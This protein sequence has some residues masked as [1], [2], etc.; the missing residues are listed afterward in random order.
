MTRGVLIFLSIFCILWI[1]SV[2]AETIELKNGEDIVG[3]IVQETEEALV[4]SKPEGSFIFSIS[5]D[6]IKNVRPSTPAE[7]Q[8]ERLRKK[9]K[10]KVDTEEEKARREK[11]KKDRLE[12]YEQE[13]LAAKRARGR[14][15]I[16][17][18]ED[19]F[20]VVEALL[21]NKIK[22]ALLVDSGASRVVI[23]EAIAKQ[24][25]I[26]DLDE[27]PKIHATLADGSITTGIAITL[28]SVKVGD[29]EVKDVDTTVSKTPPGG[30]LDGLLGMT[31]LQY[32]HV[33]LDSKENCL[34][35]EKY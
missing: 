30:G 19:R 22:A 26:E 15:K 32:F 31:F 28:D 2:L 27:K 12:K 1:S 7:L 5:R 10:G 24:L 14:I 29:S 16:K 18:L 17:F 13:V 6:R 21:N 25:G 35:L 4:V 3:E 8:R 34:I 23:S 33:K 11:I 9:S 20:G